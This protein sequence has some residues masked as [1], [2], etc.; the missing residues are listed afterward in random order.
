MAELRLYSVHGFRVLL[1]LYFALSAAIQSD[2]YASIKF[3]VK[4]GTFG[5]FG[6]E[7][8][9][10][11]LTDENKTIYKA[12][13]LSQLHYANLTIPGN[14]LNH[15]ITSLNF[16]TDF[17]ARCSYPVTWSNLSNNHQQFN[18]DSK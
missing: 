3:F 15:C 16:L 4:A 18:L 2:S 5:L 9:L 12:G 11:M 6:I 8:S 10:L 14:Q 1:N 17:D 13:F 7:P